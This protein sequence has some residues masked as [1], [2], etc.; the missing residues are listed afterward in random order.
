MAIKR[1]IALFGALAVLSCVAMLLVAL[2]GITEAEIA[3]RS[4]KPVADAGFN[5]VG[6]RISLWATLGS[7][8][9]L[10]GLSWATLARKITQS[11]K[12]IESTIAEA[13]TNLDFVA[14]GD[15]ISGDETGKALI[16]F[17]GLLSR[18]RESIGSIR[19]SVEQMTSATEE[20]DQ[21]SRKIARNS[22]LQSD[23]S[24]NMASAMEE[25]TVSVSMVAEQADAASKH[26]H[27][28]QRA[29]EESA[30][31]ILATVNC[32]QEISDTVSE[33]AVRIKTLRQDCDSISSV[34]GMIRDI[35]EQTNLLALNAAIEAAR[36]G[37][38][39]RGFAVVADE[40]R[41]LAERTRVSTQEIGSLLA[42]MQ[43]SARQAVDSMS[44]TEKAV[45]N[46][47]INAGQAGNAIERLRSGA[48][49]TAS[50]V[51]DITSA[52][53]EQE[54]A[55][56]SI[57]HNIE[58][59]AQMSEQN[60]AAAKASAV[61]IGHMTEVGFDLAQ[62]LSVFRLTTDEKKIVL[63]AAL[64]NAET[65][66]SVRAVIAMAHILMER[67]QGRIVLKVFPNGV[68]GAEKEILDQ[69]KT[70]T[71]D[72]GRANVALLAKECPLAGV[73]SL[74]YLFDSMAHL[75]AAIDGALG[76][77]LLESCSMTD[78][79][80][81]AVY[82]AGF[83]SVYGNKPIRSPADLRDM[84]MR[85]MQSDLWEAIAE[86]MGA[87]PTPLA[88]DQVTPA[89]RTGLIDCAENSAIVFDSY[90]HQDVF[91]YFCSTEHAIVPEML[92]FSKKRWEMLSESDRTQIAEAARESV[93]LQRSLYRESENAMRKKLS[94]AKVIFVTNVNKEA[95]RSAVRSV[96]AKFL[97]DPKQKT[98]VEAIGAL[99]RNL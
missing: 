61:S 27:E 19:E 78:F 45:E 60:S 32:I 89:A 24:A 88:Q 17:N 3:L 80:G 48:E 99:R 66:P 69:I 52:M 28:S 40:V 8:T 16:A 84:K 64:A 1:N 34:A 18:L 70:G 51:A 79:V 90:K 54:T 74:P 31:V 15:V 10:I 50:T 95:F 82:D 12:R 43:D 6:P 2:S 94:D 21:S 71:L 87:I 42:R 59:I 86:A 75:H 81:L 47:V 72:I 76:K 67:S 23:A 73:L 11:F 38:Q 26:T 25:M 5:L 83:R 62:T 35:A 65:H 63:R 41:K 9:V 29:A 56:T 36:A 46:G 7:A 53:R 14:R 96:Y 91:K 85:V 92:L 30:A 33:A 93:A 98:L 37:E 13:S 77:N 20:V 39:G 55:S 22:Q 57:A 68:F 49:A 4:G 97:V 58:Q 44:Q